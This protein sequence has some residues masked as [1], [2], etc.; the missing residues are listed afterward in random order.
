M[1]PRPVPPILSRVMG[2]I[3]RHAMIEPCDHIG[4]AVSGGIDSVVLLDILASL[5]EELPITLTV[6]HL[7][8]GIRGKEAARDQ[9]FV[10][11]LS[12]RYTL[13]YLGQEVDVPAYKKD[14][15][16]SLQQ[17]A[18]ELRYLFF[19]QAMKTLVLD[20]VAIGQTADDQAETVLMRLIRGGGQ[21]VSREYPRSG[22]DISAL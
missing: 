3:H 8:H 9:R 13:P 22:I 10:Q 14:K 11:E 17:A 19:E 20:K 6:L 16:L 1:P 15:S 21:G 18:R 12:K 5:R 7:N 2:T 4:V